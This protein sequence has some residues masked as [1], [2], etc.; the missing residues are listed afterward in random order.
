[1]EIQEL[2]F[3]PLCFHGEQ[4][5]AELRLC[6]TVHLNRCDLRFVHFLGVGILVAVLL[7]DAHKVIAQIGVRHADDILFGQRIQTV[8][9]TNNI[10]IRDLIN[11]RVH[12]RVSTVTVVLLSDEFVALHI[13]N[14]GFEQFFGELTFLQFLHFGE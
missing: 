7:I 12:Q 9:M 6:V 13:T 14:D 4:V 10:L 1:M 11:K 3:L 2:R 5:G 8:E